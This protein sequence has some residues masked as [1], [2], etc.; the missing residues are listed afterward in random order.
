MKVSV[1]IPNYNHAPFLVH[2]IES[3]LNQTYQNFEVII[4]DDC[5]TDNSREIIEKYRNHEKVSHINYN[6]VNS[7]S[8]FKQWEKGIS[9]ANGDWIWIAE[10]DDWCELIFLQELIEK[11][12]ASDTK[13]VSLAFCN[14]LR[15][16][17]NQILYFAPVNWILLQQDGNEF[18]KKRMLKTNTILNASMVLFNKSKYLKIQKDWIEFKFC[19]DWLFWIYIIRNSEIIEVG[20]VLNYFRTHDKNVS[21]SSTVNGTEHNETIKLWGILN[22]KNIIDYYS[23]SKLLFN[24]LLKIK[25]DKYLSK[26]NKD[27]LKNK[28]VKLIGYKRYIKFTINTYLKN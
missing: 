5:S 17:E 11:I 3:V 9:F 15:F 28:V 10:S 8:T 20:K 13:N 26:N 12:N 21:N 19:G 14:T 18:I 2:R 25:N 16:S 27:K 23:Y 24:Y 6:G 7:G 22:K 4:L 1:I